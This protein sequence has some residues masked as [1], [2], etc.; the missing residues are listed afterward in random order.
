MTPTARL[1]TGL[2]LLVFFGGTLAVLAP[3]TLGRAVLD[4]AG[5]PAVGTVTDKHQS[6]HWGNRYQGRVTSDHV[7]VSFRTAERE[8]LSGDYSVS[9]ATYDGAFVGSSVDVV[10]WPPLPQLNAVEPTPWTDPIFLAL[11]GLSVVLIWLCGATVIR[12]FS[13]PR[14]H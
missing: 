14:T 5:S 1:F 2:L 7:V 8:S 13:P 12:S 4:L 6:L 10:Y 11:F 9:R 3:F